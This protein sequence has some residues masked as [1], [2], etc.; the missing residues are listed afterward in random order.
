MAKALVVYYSMFGNT[1]KVANALATG[2]K[3]GGVEVEVVKVDSVKFEELAQVDLLC[4][5]SPVQAWNMAK[6][7]KEFVERLKSVEGLKGKK[8]FA[9]DTKIKG[10]LAGGATGKIEGKLK[11]LGLTI[12]RPGESA[13]VKGR[14]GPLEETAEE[15]F[16][17]IGAELAKTL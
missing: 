8:G 14:E 17:Q 2:L 10:R 15:K 7:V 16:K 1:E 5:G 12:A 9:F 4:I 11:D 13:I 3:S 6:P